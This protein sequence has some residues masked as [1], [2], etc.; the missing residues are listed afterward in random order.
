MTQRPRRTLPERRAARDSRQGSSRRPAQGRGNAQTRR[1]GQVGRTAQG[2]RPNPNAQRRRPAQ[3]RRRPVRRRRDLK[4]LL[5]IPVAAL[6]VWF[7]LTHY[8]FLI[9]NVEVVGAG[10][11]PIQDVVRLSGIPLGG[12]L[13][14]VSGQALRANVESNGRLAFVSVEKKL[15][16]TLVLT[17]RQRSRDAITTLAGKL[18]VLDSDG[19]VV[20]AGDAAPTD[21][22]P[23]VLGLKASTYRVGRQVDA[24]DSRLN[25]MKAV[26]EA[27]KAQNAAGYVSEI[28]LTHL[29]EI[30]RAS[31]R[32][33][34]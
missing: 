11:M 23:Y 29:S 28:N 7:V 2:R 26:L 8:V 16:N 27:L 19:Y 6:V 10:D 22:L 18:L 14:D 13:D 20:S 34:V 32:E 30:G 4:W 21:S 15:P 3:G 25:A 5:A 31:C 9:R 24:P 1:P 17:V 33:R 12:R